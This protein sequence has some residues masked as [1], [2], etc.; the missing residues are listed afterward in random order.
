MCSL[1]KV[2]DQLQ[3]RGE[4]LTI[5]RRLVVEAL[6]GSGCH[7]TIGD[8]RH[9]IQQHHAGYDLQEPTVYRILQWLKDLQLVSQTDMG[10]A[11][12][13]YELVDDPP[14]HHLVCLACGAVIDL[15]DGFFDPLR[16]GLR[17]EYGFEPRIEHMAIYGLCEGCRSS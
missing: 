17:D 16:A 5:Q 15:D 12:I 6:C 2:L 4:R 7:L 1:D 10:E 8:V 9:Y 13:V 11:G 3:A 14:H